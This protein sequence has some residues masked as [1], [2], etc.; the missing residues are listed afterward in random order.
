MNKK[1]WLTGGLSIIAI[2]ITVFI[3]NNFIMDKAAVAE[4]KAAAEAEALALLPED[5]ETSVASY[6]SLTD[7]RQRVIEYSNDVISAR[8]STDGGFNTAE[9]TGAFDGSL[10]R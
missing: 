6:N 3:Y 4:Q 8:F 5:F 7:T 2:F 9:I 1:I 10:S